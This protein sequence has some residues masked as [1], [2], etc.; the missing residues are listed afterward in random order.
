MRTI[1]KHSNPEIMISGMSLYTILTLLSRMCLC[2]ENGN[3]PHKHA[4]ISIRKYQQDSLKLLSDLTENAP[5]II[6]CARSV[7]LSASMKFDG[8]LSNAII[9]RILPPEMPQLMNKNTM[10]ISCKRAMKKPPLDIILKV[11][12]ARKVKDIIENMDELCSSTL[13][14]FY[15]KGLNYKE[16]AKVC[17]ISINTVGPRL[18]RCCNKF[19]EII[20]KNVELV[21]FFLNRND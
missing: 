5:S 4:M 14:L 15:L 12:Y 3:F 17:K 10:K 7:S 2:G 20:E 6:M 16:M 13:K 1:W 11:E 21:N 9:S 19:K 8:R 18:T